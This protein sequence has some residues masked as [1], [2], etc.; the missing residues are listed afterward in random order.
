MTSIADCMKFLAPNPPRAMHP[1]AEQAGEKNTFPFPSVISYTGGALIDEGVSALKLPRRRMAREA[2]WFCKRATWRWLLQHFP[3]WTNQAYAD[4]VGAS[5][6]WVKIWKKRLKA[7]DP[8]D[9]T[10][11]HAHSSARKTPAPPAA[12][13]CR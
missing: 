7:A 5:V 6:G 3:H 4:Y 9:L 2:D 8:G 1:V 11:L 13:P 10:V 12:S